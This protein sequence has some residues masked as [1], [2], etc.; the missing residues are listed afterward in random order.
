M[1][2]WGI[3]IVSHYFSVFGVPGIGKFDEEWEDRE[4]TR[5]LNKNRSDYRN[6]HDE[7]ELE[8]RPLEKRRNSRWDDEDLV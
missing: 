5:E 3:G 8:L 4:I 1:L 7:E 2:G 6:D